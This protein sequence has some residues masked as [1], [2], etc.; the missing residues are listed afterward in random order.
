MISLS[1]GVPA[2]FATKGEMPWRQ[3]LT[4]S[5]EDPGDQAFLGVRLSFTLPTLEP[6]GHPL[7]VDNLCEPVLSILIN[8]RGFFKGRRPNLLWWE[9][10]KAR[11]E[12]CGVR[13]ILEK[14]EPCGLMSELGES[15]FNQLYSGPLPSGATDP[16][17]PNWLSSLEV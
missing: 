3:T 13:V 8:N 12:N 17:I 7:D 16:D 9:A 11:G 2:T 6:K 10:T 15:S 5:I 4:K 1:A 14:S